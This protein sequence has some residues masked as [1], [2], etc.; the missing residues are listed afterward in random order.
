[1]FGWDGN[2][3]FKDKR[4][5]QAVSM[6][7][8]REGVIDALDNRDGFAREGLDLQVAYNTVVSA[9]YTGYW[10]D[11]LNE[12][13]FGASA[14][15]L[16][17]NPTEAKKL[18][19]AANMMGVEFDFH[20][21]STPQFPIQQRVV[22]LYNAMFLEAGLKP[23]LNG[24]NNGPEYQD[25]YYYGYQSKGYAA[26]TKKGYGGIAAGQERPFATLALMVHGTLHKDGAFYHGMSPDGTNLQNGDPKVN[27]LASKIKA[28]YDVGKQVTLTHDLI[29]YF[30]DQSYYIP[31]V[32]VAKGFT[33]WWPIGN[34]GVFSNGVSPNLWTE[35]HVN[36]WLDTT[37]KPFA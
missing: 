24:I 18:I 9:G 1:M 26:G 32:S 13:D 16:K 2:A 8:D 29:R 14:K 19:E 28:E 22:E 5:R 3:P 10:L 20:Y 34:L 37:K 11:P 17:H 33:L 36:W 27:E 21:N 23:K 30:T 35:R 25:N 12:K 7:I 15:Y 6:L 4:M 31:Q